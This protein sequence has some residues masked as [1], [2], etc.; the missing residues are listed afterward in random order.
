MAEQVVD[1]NR[2]RDFVLCLRSQRGPDGHLPERGKVAVE[3]RLEREPAFFVEN[4]AP[5]ARH[6]FG[7]R[8]EIEDRIRHHRLVAGAVEKTMRL[9]IDDLAIAGDPQHPARN[10]VL[11]DLALEELVDPTETLLLEPRPL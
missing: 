4:Q 8:S 3:P 10:A 7:H 1:I 2:I 11:S 6:H 5:Y 9:V